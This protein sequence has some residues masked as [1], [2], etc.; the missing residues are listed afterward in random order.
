MKL[1]ILL[2]YRIDSFIPF[3]GNNNP[4]QKEIKMNFDHAYADYLKDEDIKAISELEKKTG[5]RILAYYTPPASANLDDTVL[6][7]IRELEKRL[8]VRL[9][10]YNDQ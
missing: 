2:L 8:C 4:P 5:K 7:K 6:G 3:S 9:V 1:L 10:A